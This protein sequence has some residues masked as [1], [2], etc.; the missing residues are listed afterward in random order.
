MPRLYHWTKRLCVFVTCA[1]TCGRRQSTTEPEN[2]LYSS[3]VQGQTWVSLCSRPTGNDSGFPHTR[4][5]RCRLASVT[6]KPRAR[7]NTADTS[8]Q[9]RENSPGRCPHS[10]NRSVARLFS[11]VL[12]IHVVVFRL[13]SRTYG[14]CNWVERLSRYDGELVTVIFFSF[15]SQWVNIFVLKG[16]VSCKIWTGDSI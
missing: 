1:L 14:I 8:S 2:P 12:Q 15:C 16:L 6:R 10:Y 13:I 11:L 4:F 5:H 3:A 7:N 9:R